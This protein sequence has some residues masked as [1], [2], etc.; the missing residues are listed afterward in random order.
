MR[1]HKISRKSHNLPPSYLW[2]KTTFFNKAFVR[3][4]HDTKDSLKD[5]RMIHHDRVNSRMIDRILTGNG[6]VPHSAT[7]P[8][9]SLKVTLS[10]FKFFVSIKRRIF[11]AMPSIPRTCNKNV[12]VCYNHVANINQL[13]RKHSLPRSTAVTVKKVDKPIGELARALLSFK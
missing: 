7:K 8:E 5:I 4:P 1:L 3:H 13:N 2:P 12:N 9:I 11:R 10:Y 6:K